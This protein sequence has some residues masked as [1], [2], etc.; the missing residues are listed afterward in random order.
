MFFE[1]LKEFS[2]YFPWFLSNSEIVFR[3]FAE[4]VYSSTYPLAAHHERGQKR[5]QSMFVSKWL[6]S[7]KLKSEPQTWSLGD[8]VIIGYGHC[9]VPCPI[10]EVDFK[11]CLFLMAVIQ[12]HVDDLL[13]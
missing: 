8:R 6:H 5:S 9:W 4:G 11:L 3:Y 7:P 12:E 1:F 10:L 2:G 13:I